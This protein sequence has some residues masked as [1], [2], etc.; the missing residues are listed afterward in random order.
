M[1]QGPFWIFLFLS[2]G[3]ASLFG[4]LAVAAWSEARR[5]ERESYYRNDMLKKL[6]EMQTSGAAAALEYLNTE[7]QA[8]AIR[9]VQKQREGFALGGLINAAVGIG[10]M[11]FL[12]AIVHDEPVFY[13]GL[14]PTLIGIALLIYTYL[15]APKTVG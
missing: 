11:V 13:V 14:I 15:L 2:V 10:L 4:F 7:R 6:A 1:F 9:R 12:R 8:A 5:Q 3:A